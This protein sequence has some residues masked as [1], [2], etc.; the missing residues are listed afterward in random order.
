MK[1]DTL[2]DLGLAFQA[3]KLRDK[4]EEIS[5]D[6]TIFGFAIRN[7]LLNGRSLKDVSKEIME[8]HK[9]NAEITEEVVGKE[10]IELIKEIYR[11]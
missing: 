4:L 10:T 11:F 3:M 5:P 6:H 7:A 2:P 9:D 8:Q 1:N